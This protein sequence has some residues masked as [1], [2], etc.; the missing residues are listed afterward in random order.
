MAEDDIY[1]SKGKYEK[2]IRRIPDLIRPLDEKRVWK[3]GWRKY[4]CKNPENL[5]YFNKLIPIFAARDL[6]FVRRLRLFRVLNL[7]C[8]AAE[9]TLADCDRDDTNAIVVFAHGQLHS[10]NSKGD[11]IKD[12]KWLWKVLLPERDERGRIDDAIVPYPVRHLSAKIDR[13]KEKCKDRLTFPEYQKIVKAFSGD[14]RLQAF[15]TLANESLGRPQEILYVRLRDVEMHDNWAKV[16]ISE[17]GKEGT[18]FLQCIESFL[19]LADWLNEHPLRHDQDAFLFITLDDSHR[20]GQLR[21]ETI[22]KHLRAKLGLLGIKKRITCYSF[23]RGGVTYRRLRGD[24]DAVIQHV[25]R[26]TSTKQLAVYDQSGP[27]DVLKGELAKRGLLQ[28]R[29]ALEFKQPNKT[30]LFCK[31]MNGIG[32]DCCRTCKR[33]LD[34]ERITKQMENTVVRDRDKISRE[35]REPRAKYETINGFMDKLLSQNPDLMDVMA[36]RARGMDEAQQ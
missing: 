21:P 4:Q 33:P 3:T 8:H 17:H 31:T 16:W 23:K 12:M 36:K 1:G 2:F 29:E 9:K 14:K 27:S 15:L 5:Q 18:G 32:D 10:W 25:A 7:I 13:S 11:F 34:R 20:Y 35:L 26:W 22:N 24:S 19:Y 6:S 30:C 28:G